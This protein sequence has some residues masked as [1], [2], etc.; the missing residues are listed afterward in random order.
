[1]DLSV[2]TQVDRQLTFP[3]RDLLEARTHVWGV[4]PT[5]SVDSSEVYVPEEANEYETDSNS[6]PSISL[7]VDLKSGAMHFKKAQSI[8]SQYPEQLQY[9]VHTQKHEGEKEMNSGHY[10]EIERLKEYYNFTD[11]DRLKE[12]LSN[13]AHLISFL[14]EAANEI[15]K[16]FNS[17]TRIDLALTEDSPDGEFLYAYIYVDLPLE[18]VEEKVRQFEEEWLLDNILRSEGRFS[19]NVWWV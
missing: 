11:E 4:V 5:A 2:P 12:F 1:M 14:F 9:E 16:R 19:Y 6:Y 17:D 15:R 18:N 7:L 3:N 10:Q 8:K 13:N